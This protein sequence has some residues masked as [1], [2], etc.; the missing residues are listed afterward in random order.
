MF[1]TDKYNSGLAFPPKLFTAVMIIRLFSRSTFCPFQKYKR[2][3]LDDD[4]SYPELFIPKL[5][6]AI[7]NTFLIFILS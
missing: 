1:H 7:V 2:I 6:K 5:F 4:D 3:G